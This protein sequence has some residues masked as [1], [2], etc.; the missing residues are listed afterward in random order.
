MQP[1]R[2]FLLEIILPIRIDEY[3]FIFCTLVGYF[4]VFQKGPIFAAAFFEG[5]ISHT[6]TVF[7]C[8]MMTFLCIV[9]NANPTVISVIFN[10][11]FFD[12]TRKIIL[13]F[14]HFKVRKIL[15]VLILQILSRCAYV[16]RTQ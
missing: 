5:F 2:M 7:Y 13:S 4:I 3:L 8:G 1:I 12:K 15:R 9:R 14:C 10:K 11:I 16:T 6:G